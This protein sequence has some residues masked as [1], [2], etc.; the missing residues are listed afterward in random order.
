MK[1]A[2]VLLEYENKG[3]TVNTNTEEDGGRKV[4]FFFFFFFFN[5]CNFV[6]LKLILFYRQRKCLTSKLLRPFQKGLL[7]G[8]SWQK[9]RKHKMFMPSRFGDFFIFYF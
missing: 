9:R 4:F 3:L 5:H 2:Q 7:G 1:M 8:F 6:C